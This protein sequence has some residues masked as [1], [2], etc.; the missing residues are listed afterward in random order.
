MLISAVLFTSN[1]SG[2]HVLV[3]RST[4]SWTVLLQIALG[5]WYCFDEGDLHFPP[6]K[7]VC[8]LDCCLLSP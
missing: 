7:D 2:L 5:I 1:I 8:E 3:F 6:R 4:G